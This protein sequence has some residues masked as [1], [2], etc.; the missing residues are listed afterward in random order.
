MLIKDPHPW[1][2]FNDFTNSLHIDLFWNAK[3]STPILLVQSPL[4]ARLSEVENQLYMNLLL[5]TKTI[6]HFVSVHERPFCKK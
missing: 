6:D 3:A 1:L 5:I 2:D 4:C